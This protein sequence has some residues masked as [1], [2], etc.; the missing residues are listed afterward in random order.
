V[1]RQ[2]QPWF[3]FK[4]KELLAEGEP[5]ESYRRFQQELRGAMQQE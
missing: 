1:E 2:G 5:L 4:S 3:V